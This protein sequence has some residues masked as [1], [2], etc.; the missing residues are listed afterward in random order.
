MEAD[1]HRPY[2]A[3]R[4]L[5][6]TLGASSV[7]AAGHVGPWLTAA[8]SPCSRISLMITFGFA[9]TKSCG[10]LHWRPHRRLAR[11]ARGPTENHELLGGSS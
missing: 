3:P 8:A 9:S 5:R 2:S 4:R 11:V 7:T 10:R 1:L 6:T